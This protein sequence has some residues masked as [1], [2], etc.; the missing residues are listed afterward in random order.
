MDFT[1]NAIG[2]KA[3]NFVNLGLLAVNALD[4]F[5]TCG[6]PD[7]CLQSDRKSVV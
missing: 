3:P 2:T 6:T 7:T 5:N 4:E 1:S